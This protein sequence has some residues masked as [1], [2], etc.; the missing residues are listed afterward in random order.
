M[1]DK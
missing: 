1:D